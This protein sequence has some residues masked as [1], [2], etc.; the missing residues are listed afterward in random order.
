MA[1]SASLYT[2]V[3]ALPVVLDHLGRGL[4]H[5]KGVSLLLG[6]P[7][8]LGSFYEL[9]GHIGILFIEE[10]AHLPEPI[11]VRERGAILVDLRLEALAVAGLDRSDRFSRLH[12][13]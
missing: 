13:N 3:L 9:F 8:R 7:L 11:V 4:R 12:L 6:I 5:L 1:T 10:V 2:P